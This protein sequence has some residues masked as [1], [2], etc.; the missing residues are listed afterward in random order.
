MTDWTT[1]I[2]AQIDNARARLAELDLTGARARAHA[3]QQR[4]DATRAEHKI[5][6]QSF[7]VEHHEVAEAS[8]AAKQARKALEEM[9]GREAR[10]RAEIQRLEQSLAIPERLEAAGF[11]SEQAT[12]AVM[13]HAVQIRDAETTLRT[14]EEQLAATHAAIEQA[15]SQAGAR[16]L[17]A[18]KKGEQARPDDTAQLVAQA[19]ALELAKIAAADELASLRRVH[20][21]MVGIAADAELKVRKIAAEASGVALAAFE[22]EYVERLA[23]HMA[24]HWRAHGVNWR[25]PDLHGRAVERS[26]AILAEI[27]H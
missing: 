14:L 17:E 11:G 2:R 21:G 27:G 3:A 9:E 4:A 22:A 23:Q 19:D 20:E 18:A 24:N 25:A 26:Q 12:A 1:R 15:R 10:L 5:G 13:R 6:T 7:T 16:M 8:G